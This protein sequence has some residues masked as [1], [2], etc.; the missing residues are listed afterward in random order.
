M[1]DEKRSALGGDVSAYNFANSIGLHSIWLNHQQSR[2]FGLL[3][4]L[5]LSLGGSM[6]AWGQELSL[7][8]HL[9][10]PDSVDRT[11]LPIH[12]NVEG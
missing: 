1:E 3:S 12:R 7:D 5:A 8:H 2:W 11:V 4:F 9:W 10:E 6:I